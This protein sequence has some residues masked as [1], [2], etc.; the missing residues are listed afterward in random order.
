M[1]RAPP[2][3]YATGRLTERRLQADQPPTGRE[4]PHEPND[5]LLGNPERDE[6]V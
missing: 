3:A 4:S 5:P 1:S 6:P 2:E